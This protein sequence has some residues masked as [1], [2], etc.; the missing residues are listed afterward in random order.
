MYRKISKHIN[1]RY[2]AMLLWKYVE[3][4]ISTMSCDASIILL[5][6]KI[7]KNING[8][9]RCVDENIS[10]VSCESPHFVVLV[11]LVMEKS[12]SEIHLKVYYLE[13]CSKGFPQK[14]V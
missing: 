14:A 8:I 6:G 3:R 1:Q 4:K 2:V 13:C 10:T 11:P 9:L 5:I 12:G 7:S